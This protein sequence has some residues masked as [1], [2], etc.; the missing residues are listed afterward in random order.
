V[1]LL[2]ADNITELYLQVYS[3]CDAV[4]DSC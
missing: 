3:S 1:L 2:Q 4:T